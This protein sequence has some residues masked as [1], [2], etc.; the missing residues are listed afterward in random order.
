[1]TDLKETATCIPGTQWYSIDRCLLNEYRQKY[2]HV[3]ECWYKS[4]GIERENRD[5]HSRE[6]SDCKIKIKYCIP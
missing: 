4:M 6:I 3:Q 2:W 1:M 5:S